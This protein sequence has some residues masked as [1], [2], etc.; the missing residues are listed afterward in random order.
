[1]LAGACTLVLAG[2]FYLVLIDSVSPPELYALA[3]IALLA[4]AA[5]LAYRERSAARLG[6]GRWVQRAGRPVLAIPGHLVLLTR[7]A[8]A[9]LLSPR[10]RRGSFRTVSFS[11]DATQTGR[12][13]LAEMFGSIAPNTIVIGVDREAQQLVA[14][15]L[16]RQGDRDE[17]DVLGLG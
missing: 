17:I 8:I 1:V 10:A 2:A 6:T 15:Q 16:E 5:Y 13:A 4:T 3:V 11:T 14:H 7:V 12:E 9:Q